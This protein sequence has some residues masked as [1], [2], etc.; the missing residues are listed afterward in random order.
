M[1]STK[2]AATCFDGWPETRASATA[3]DMQTRAAISR[4]R[5]CEENGRRANGVW[6]PTVNRDSR[7]SSTTAVIKLIPRLSPPSSRSHVDRSHRV[8]GRRQI[9]LH[10]TNE[11]RWIDDSCKKEKLAF[12]DQQQCEKFSTNNCPLLFLNS[13]L[14]ITPNDHQYFASSNSYSLCDLTIVQRG[15]L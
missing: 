4:V 14:N 15:L 13:S 10:P 2:V 6:S 8:I 12:W 3:S 11:Y 7:H 9:R 1:S 5:L